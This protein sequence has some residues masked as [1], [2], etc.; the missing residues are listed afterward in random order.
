MILLLQ[1]YLLAGIYT[2]CWH[3]CGCLH[4]NVPAASATA[5]IVFAANAVIPAIFTHPCRFCVPAMAD[6]TAVA[7]APAL[8]VSALLLDIHV[9]FPITILFH[10]IHSVAGITVIGVHSVAGITLLLKS[11]P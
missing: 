3:P 10:S 7:G 4:C 11:L 6:A 2:V 8:L 5:A 9:G 1:A